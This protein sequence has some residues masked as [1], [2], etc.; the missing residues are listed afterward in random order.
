MM[1]DRRG[2]KDKKGKQWKQ[3]NISGTLLLS[4]LVCNR[5]LCSKVNSSVSSDGLHLSVKPIQVLKTEIVACLIC[6]SNSVCLVAVKA[7]FIK[8]CRETEQSMFSKGRHQTHEGEYFL[9]FQ[10][11]RQTAREPDIPKKYRSKGLSDDY[12]NLKMTVTIETED[13]HSKR[14]WSVLFL[15]QTMVL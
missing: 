10:L 12:R 15:I 3:M 4:S 2:R 14:M 7:F 9:E 11:G 13:K 1:V 8:L 6:V 5:Y